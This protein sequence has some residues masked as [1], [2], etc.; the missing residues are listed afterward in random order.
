MNKISKHFKSKTTKLINSYWDYKK[1]VNKQLR[2]NQ[3][4]KNKYMKNIIYG[5]KAKDKKWAKNKTNAHYF[6]IL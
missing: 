2:Q 4:D 3:E 5:N 6:D 1:L